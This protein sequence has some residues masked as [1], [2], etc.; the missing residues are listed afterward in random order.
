MGSKNK[1]STSLSYETTIKSMQKFDP[2]LDTKSFEDIDLRYLE[3]YD[4]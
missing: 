4:K 2:L 1:A 3:A